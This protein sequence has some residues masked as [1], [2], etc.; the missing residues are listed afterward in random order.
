M[1]QAYVCVCGFRGRLG[2]SPD[3]LAADLIGGL[4]GSEPATDLV[5]LS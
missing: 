4:D 1:R 2:R 3:K 5:Y